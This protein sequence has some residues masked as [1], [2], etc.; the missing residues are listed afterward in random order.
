MTQQE[1]AR[2]TLAYDRVIGALNAV[3]QRLTPAGRPPVLATLAAELPPGA[4]RDCAKAAA[5]TAANL[6]PQLEATRHEVGL[7]AD[8][9]RSAAAVRKGGLR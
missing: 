7:L 1:A 4:A 6:V 2:L 3:E 5:S 9:A 8:Q